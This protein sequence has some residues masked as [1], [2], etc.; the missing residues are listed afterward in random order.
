MILRLISI[1]CNR[2]R[3][4]LG[5]AFLWPF[6]VPIH[7]RSHLK[8]QSRDP[9]VVGRV[10][11]GTC[12]RQSSIAAFFI[13]VNKSSVPAIVPEHSE[14]AS[15]VTLVENHNVDVPAASNRDTTVLSPTAGTLSQ[16]V[17]A[18]VQRDRGRLRN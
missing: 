16:S 4:W 5:N 17:S 14:S 13:N 11:N 1:Y 10:Q 2:V 18:L 8:K 15:F 6:S 3:H 9:D 12:Q 7:K